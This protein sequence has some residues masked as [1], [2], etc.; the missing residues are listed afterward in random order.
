MDLQGLNTFI[1]VAELNSFTKAADRLGYSQPTVSFQI[2]QLET[3]L[4]VQLFDRVGHTI[5]LTDAGRNALAYAQKICNMSQE[6]LVGNN[7]EDKVAGTVRIALAD[8]LCEP[9]IAH[10]FAQFRKTNPNIRFNVQTAGTDKLFQ[11]LD[12][13]EADIVCT[14]DTHIYDTDYVILQEEKVD[15]NFVVS[16]QHPLA[17]KEFITLAD[18]ENQSFLLTEKGMSYRRILDETMAKYSKEIDPVLEISSTDILLKLVEQNLGISFLPDY[19]TESSVKAGTLKRIKIENFDI[20]VWKQLLHHR[21]KWIS[22]SLK[23]VI[24]FL[25]YNN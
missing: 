1:H 2:K 9:V 20:C 19:V 3:E 22:Q 4:G 11:L 24:S 16:S 18:V 15:V 23:K 8:S 13:N 6:M 21:D 10:R 17:Y 25:T 14:L 7:N 12:R 5:K